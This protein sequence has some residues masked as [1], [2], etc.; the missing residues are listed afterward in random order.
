MV[1]QNVCLNRLFI[2]NHC[3]RSGMTGSDT[4]AALADSIATN[5]LKE[6]LK[7]IRRGMNFEVICGGLRLAAL[8]KLA[9]AKVIGKRSAVKVQVFEDENELLGIKIMESS[10]QVNPCLIEL[11]NQIQLLIN[12]DKTLVQIADL[13]GRSSTYVH[14]VHDLLKLT[15]HCK[16]LVRT[17]KLTLTVAREIAKLPKPVQDAMAASIEFLSPM[18][19]IQAVHKE[20]KRQ[21]FK[22]MYT[23]PAP[24]PPQPEDVEQIRREVL[25]MFMVEHSTELRAP[26]AGRL[27]SEIKRCV[28]WQSDFERFKIKRPG[29]WAL[30]VCPR[31]GV[32][33]DTCPHGARVVY[34]ASVPDPKACVAVREHIRN[35]IINSNECR[36]T[37]RPT[38]DEQIDFEISERVNWDAVCRAFKIEWP[39]REPFF[40]RAY[41][42]ERRSHR[43]GQKRAANYYYPEMDWASVEVKVAQKMWIDMETDGVNYASVKRAQDESVFLT[44][45][46]RAEIREIVARGMAAAETSLAEFK[47]W[48][49]I[50]N[51]FFSVPD[52]EQMIYG[53]RPAVQIGKTMT[54][55]A[56]K[57]YRL[58][59]NCEQ[60]MREIILMGHNPRDYVPRLIDSSSD[61]AAALKIAVKHKFRQ[62]EI[63]QYSW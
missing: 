27:S 48:Y 22:G 61:S 5:G 33:T 46:T 28:H 9:V 14:S 36:V 44:P 10:T 49:R 26:S 40:V 19:A 52:W 56:G 55:M 24:W 60:L 1:E 6:P 58:P 51:P 59:L 25:R 45:E 18:E 16:D 35:L 30:Y 8:R 47:N 17:H 11:A 39:G 29:W 34:D 7:V 23:P 53:F 20:V 62:F 63:D 43:V 38:T 12:K 2:Q 42:A 3:D 54:A 13:M 21:R 41:Q 31:S 4:V 50:D 57:F 32:V 15:D 37:K